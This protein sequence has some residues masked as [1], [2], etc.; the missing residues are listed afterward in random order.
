[1]GRRLLSRRLSAFIGFP[2]LCGISHGFPRLFPT[3]G[4]ITY[5]LLTRPP[6]NS[7]SCPLDLHVLGPP[8]AFALS[9]DQTLQF[10][11]LTLFHALDL[12]RC[13]IRTRHH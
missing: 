3:R 7:R 10:N 2:T 1:M 5:V 9:Q 13:V 11:L 12:T 4:H 6:L 8:L